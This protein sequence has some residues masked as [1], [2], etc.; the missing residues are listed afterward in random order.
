MKIY[1]QVSESTQAKTA[2]TH[3]P[4]LLLHLHMLPTQHL[5]AEIHIILSRH[6][7]RIGLSSNLDTLVVG[8]VDMLYERVYVE[9]VE[10]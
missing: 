4:T 5:G 8:E 1:K 9:W 3:L 10:V 2:I 7:P 6:S